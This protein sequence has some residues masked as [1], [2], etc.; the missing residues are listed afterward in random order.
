MVGAVIVKNGRAIGEGYHERYGGPHAEVNAIRNAIDR[1]HTLT[2][3]T[4]YVNLEPCSHHGKTPPCAEAIIRSG[5]RRVVI[6]T[7]DPNPLVAGK[8]ILKLRSKGI[9]CTVGLLKNDATTL[10]EA[11]FKYIRS[12]MP[13]VSIKA[14]QTSDGYI[15]R[16]DGSSQ[17]ITNA[18][19]RA[20]GH[21]LRSRYDAVAVGAQTVMT[22][23]PELTV[24]MVKGRN[25]VRIVV[26]GRFTLPVQ[27][28]I[29]Q[30]IGN[31]KTVL[32][33]DSRFLRKK[34]AKARTLRNNGVQVIGVK[35]SNGKLDIR[36]V[37]KDLAG[38]NIASVLVEGG[39]RTYASFMNAKCVD[40]MWIYTAPKKFYEG[41][42]TFDGIS[43]SFKRSKRYTK[44]FSADTLCEY[45]ITYPTSR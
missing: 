10:N 25:P 36:K 8:G 1:G 40:T 18:R 7:M 30:H 42:K 38:R 5:C 35:G 44:R 2:G 17:W 32:Y 16:N 14:A 29:F 13:F 26:D 27:R 9:R 23:D 41:V 45:S 22:D 33:V 11:F 28:K 39:Q 21:R 20:F 19:S 15:A 12:G 24:R 6:G 3:A 43:V 4:I 34:N 37:L 31:A